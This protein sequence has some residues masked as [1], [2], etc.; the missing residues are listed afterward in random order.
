VA[1]CG[2]DTDALYNL[3]FSLNEIELSVA[4][5]IPDAEDGSFVGSPVEGNGIHGKAILLLAGKEP[6]LGKFVKIVAVIPMEMGKDDDFDLV[7]VDPEASKL[8]VYRLTRV[9]ATFVMVLLRVF[10][11][12]HPRIDKDLSAPSLDEKD[13][14]RV[15]DL[16][17]IALAIGPV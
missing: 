6:C 15:L 5:G 9:L 17:A 7:G 4:E 14:D 2:K 1:R 3:L 11:V 12:T 13:K 10:R 16:L 8:F